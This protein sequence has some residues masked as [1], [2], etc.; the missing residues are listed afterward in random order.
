M[1]QGRGDEAITVGG[2]S[3]HLADVEDALLQRLTD[4]GG[5]DADRV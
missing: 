1:I 5:P 4:P 3:V 2:H